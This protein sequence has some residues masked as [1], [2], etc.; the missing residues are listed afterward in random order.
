M[1]D[2]PTNNLDLKHSQF[3]LEY[4]N[5]PR[6]A[7]KTFFVICH[8]HEIVRQFPKILQFEEGKIKEVETI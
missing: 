6:F 1:F 4:I 5:D 8:D 2:E 3:L 7:H